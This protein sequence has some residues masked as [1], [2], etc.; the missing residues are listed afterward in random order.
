MSGKSKEDVFIETTAFHRAMVETIKD[1][2][3]TICPT[4]VVSALA[5][6]LKDLAAGLS[7]PE[8]KAVEETC[9]ELYPQ[10][11]LSV[12]TMKFEDTKH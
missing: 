4:A 9:N 3:L 7:E 8:Q 11:Q 5:M 6:L 10:L 1:H 2:R 12:A